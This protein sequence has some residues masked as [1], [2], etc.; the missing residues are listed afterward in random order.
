MERKNKISMQNLNV[1]I[2]LISLSL[3]NFFSLFSPNNFNSGNFILN[4]LAQDL[5][6]RHLQQNVMYL[7]RHI[8]SHEYNKRPAKIRVKNN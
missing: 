6:L 8:P 7:W 4:I 2:Q 5:R 1:T 3:Y